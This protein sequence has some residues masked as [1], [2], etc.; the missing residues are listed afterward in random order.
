MSLLPVL[1]ASVLLS[2]ILSSY[3]LG[4]L[5][6]PHALVVCG[7]YHCTFRGPHHSGP[8]HHSAAGAG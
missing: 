1:G 5:H 8:D 4:F 6:F 2:A 7:P 3:R